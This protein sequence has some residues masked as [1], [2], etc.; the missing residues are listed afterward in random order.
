L[1]FIWPQKKQK[2]KD[3]R[4]QTNKKKKKRESTKLTEIANDASNN[5]ITN[6]ILTCLHETTI[7]PQAKARKRNKEEC[8]K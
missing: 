3:D 6:R 2:T 7:T 4:K 5:K 8:N 1:N